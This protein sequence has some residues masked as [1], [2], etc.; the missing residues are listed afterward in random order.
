MFR[1]PRLHLGAGLLA[2][3]LAVEHLR[4]N[5]FA[6]GAELLGEGLLLRRRI[7]AESSAVADGEAGAVASGKAGTS[8][9]TNTSALAGGK[10]LACTGTDA[11]ASAGTEALA[12][13][14]GEAATLTNEA[15]TLA[16]ATGLPE[17]LRHPHATDALTAKA[18]H[19]L[20]VFNA[21]CLTTGEVVDAR[22]RPGLQ[23]A[24]RESRYCNRGERHGKT[25]DL[26]GAH[27]RLPM[28]VGDWTAPLHS[29]RSGAVGVK[30]FVRVFLG[31]TALPRITQT[32]A[33]GTDQ[34]CRG[35]SE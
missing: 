35:S 30:R 33:V 2:C 8:T 29:G 31:F 7:G 14:G 12:R 10:A 11:G 26:D 32:K 22:E 34:H 6:L 15:M 28:S 1:G 5:G 24:L 23:A 20:L 4:A 21:L 25:K 17:A 13:T 18:M 27:L 3:Q 9:G 16:E 19:L